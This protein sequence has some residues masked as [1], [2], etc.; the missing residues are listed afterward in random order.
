MWLPRVVS[1]L[2]ISFENNRH[3]YSKWASVA[4]C[5][6]HNEA[7]FFIITLKIAAQLNIYIRIPCST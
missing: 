7:Q 2:F 6:V 1:L 5:G 4:I 3:T